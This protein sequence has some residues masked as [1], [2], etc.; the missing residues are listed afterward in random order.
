MNGA[1]REA[2]EADWRKTFDHS[3]ARTSDAKTIAEKTRELDEYGRTYK[4]RLASVENIRKELEEKMRELDEVAG[5]HETAF[6]RMQNIERIAEERLQ[7]IT[8]YSKAITESTALTH[9]IAEMAEERVE[10]LEGINEVLFSTLA[11][12][13]RSEQAVANIVKDA[14]KDTDTQF[15][16]YRTANKELVRTLNAAFDKITHRAAEVENSH[17]AFVTSVATSREAERAMSEMVLETVPEILEPAETGPAPV[18]VKQSRKALKAYEVWNQ[19]VALRS[20]GLSLIGTAAEMG[21][22]AGSLRD[23]I[24]REKKQRNAILPI[25]SARIPLPVAVLDETPALEQLDTLSTIKALRTAGWS[26]RSIAE[27]MG[28]PL[29]VIAGKFYYAQKKEHKKN[30]GI[31]VQ[32]ADAQWE[33]QQATVIATQPVEANDDWIDRL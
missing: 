1:V 17:A 20:K 7:R 6:A 9:A 5:A 19:I 27:K 16:A 24:Y 30:S 13:Y 32:A 8:F 4:A 12:V 21:V 3:I 23:R 14:R 22:S 29:P 33:E 28:V 15:A 10:G 18:L 31:S 11:K 26:F 2:T 25:R